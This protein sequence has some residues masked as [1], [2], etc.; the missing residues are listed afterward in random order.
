MIS[1]ENRFAQSWHVPI[2]VLIVSLIHHIVAGLLTFKSVVKILLY[3]HF[4]ERKFFGRTF[5]RDYLVLN[6]LRDEI[7]FLSCDFFYFHR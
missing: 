7:V 3:F 2:T 4:N 5:E 1:G 6:I